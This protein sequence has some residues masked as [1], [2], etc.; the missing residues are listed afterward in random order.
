[1]IPRFKP[2]LNWRELAAA[3]S[4]P[5][6]DDV[7]R[8]ED[9]FAEK[10]GQKHAIAFPYGR[11]GII[12]LFEALGL[13]GKQIIC[14]AYTCVVVAHAIMVSGNEPVFVDSA[15]DDF[16]M[17]LDQ[18]PELITERTG[19]IIATS[20]FGYPVDLDKLD[21]IRKR[22]PDVRIIQDCAHSF[23]AEWKGRPVQ[24]EGKAAIFAL[25]I[26]KM[27]TSVFGGMVTTDD[28]VLA[29]RLRTIR[30]KELKPAS[31]VKSMRRLFY[32][33]AVYPAFWEPIY[34]FINRLERS[35]LLNRFVKYYDEGLIDMPAD[36]FEQMASVEARV[37]MVQLAKYETIIDNKR[38]H[39]SRYFDAL[40]DILVVQ[41][42]HPNDGAT[43][44]HFT[45]LVP[46]RSPVVQEALK[47]SIQLGILIEYCIPKMAAYKEYSNGEEFPNS[48][49]FAQHTVNLPIYAGLTKEDNIINSLKRW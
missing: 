10:M 5:R 32:L 23:A 48:S 44:S 9:A 29:D 16:N 33:V 21:E 4:L 47:D 14:P 26:S 19:A 8:F 12:M 3:F 42:P 13:K 40:R 43:Y 41:L 37:G 34:G 38:A 15:K 39:A 35:G 22:F 24:R 20:I 45:L 36:Y 25:N 30:D 7:A 1:M 2:F 31:F 11:T 49:I 18:V 28:T 27:I 46:E 6:R 17:D